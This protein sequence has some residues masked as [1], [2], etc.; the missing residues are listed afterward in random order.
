MDAATSAFYVD[1]YYWLAAH[2]P[3]V[4]GVVVLLIWVAAWRWLWPAAMSKRGV[5]NDRTLRAMKAEQEAADAR[6][7]WE[8]RRKRGPCSVMDTLG[9]DDHVGRPR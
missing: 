4:V 8:D 6:R 1:A 3:Q 5:L 7:T 9:E 2:W